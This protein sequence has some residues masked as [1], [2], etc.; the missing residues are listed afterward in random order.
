[1]FQGIHE[2]LASP[3]FQQLQILCHPLRL[4]FQCLLHNSQFLSKNLTVNSFPSDVAVVIS[5]SF[6]EFTVPLK[7]S[8][9]FVSLPEVPSSAVRV[10]GLC[11][12]RKFRF[13]SSSNRHCN[14]NFKM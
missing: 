11:T 10:D 1:M 7:E 5:M 13:F 9:T 4:Q 14:Q 2:L 6:T 3:K 8:W 12:P